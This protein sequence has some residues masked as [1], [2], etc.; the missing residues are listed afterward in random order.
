[1]HL[2][3]ASGDPH[4]H[5]SPLFLELIRPIEAPLVRED[6]ILHGHQVNDWKLEPLRGVERHQGHPIGGG[7]PGVGVGNQRRGL[8]KS[9]EGIDIDI[10]ARIARRK[11]VV[12]LP[13]RRDEFLHVGESILPVFVVLRLFRQHVAV[14]GAV[15]HCLQQ[16]RHRGLPARRGREFRV[17]PGETGQGR[18]RPLRHAGNRGGVR[19]RLEPGQGMILGPGS[20]PVE[21]LTADAPRGHVDHPQERLVV[22][23]VSQQPQPGDH[24][25]DLTAFEKLQP[26]DE[27]IGDPTAPQRQ[28]ERPRQG[29]G[30]EQD[31]EV[32][33]RPL[34]GGGGG[35]DLGGDAIRLLEPRAVEHDP[36]RR[37]GGRGRDQPLDLP[38]RVVR[39]QPIGCAEDV[40]GAPVVVFELHHRR[41]RVVPLELQDVADAGPPPTVDRLV[42]VAGDGE[43]G[44]VDRQSPQD[45]VLHR[46]GVLIFIHEDEPIASIETPPEFGV[47][48]EQSGDMHQQVV[49]VDG[50]GPQQH[51]LVDRPDPP[52]EIIDGLAPAGLEG[53]GGQ[54]VVLGPRDHP[55]DPV[56]GRMGRRDSQRLHRPLEHPSGIIGIENRVIARQSHLAGMPA[57]EAGPKAMKCA[58][59]HRLRADQFGDPAAHLVGRLVGEGQRHD[60]LRWH[61]LGNQV[62]QTM[63]D[64]TGLSATGP[65]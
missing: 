16:G 50:V 61:T 48:D 39:D 58:H 59:L 25:A 31:R 18:G 34:S 5:Q 27:L 32:A 60:P 1:M 43:V 45:A 36:D 24:V 54:E 51:P 11:G 41:R 40:G 23:R 22:T 47:L 28:F 15:E 19:D 52:G 57:E 35:G 17:Q 56:D 63:R 12:E 8:E 13:R 7:V 38:P 4:E 44:M 53:L 3:L 20:K 29:V 46:V 42:G 26:A 64:D 33:A 65:C 6:S 21:R 62:G 30:P 37:A 10:A 49:E 2:L 9:P 14:A 55:G